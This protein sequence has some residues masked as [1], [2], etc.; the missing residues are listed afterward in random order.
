MSLTDRLARAQTERVAR[1]RGI[2]P[3]TLLPPIPAE[4][5]PE[6]ELA[7]PPVQSGPDRLCARCGVEGNID[8]VDTFRA[9]A[10]LSCATC[11]RRWEAAD[12]GSAPRLADQPRFRD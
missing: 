3:S 7:P 2:D 10:Y 5:T 9:T 6:P 1:A 8:L 4:P 12:L 11:G